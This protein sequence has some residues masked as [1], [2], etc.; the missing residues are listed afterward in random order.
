MAA[1]TARAVAA[2]APECVRPPRN[3]P[4]G[5]RVFTDRSSCVQLTAEIN[6][7]YRQQA[8]ALGEQP[9]H[10]SVED[11]VSGTLYTIVCVDPG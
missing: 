4:T 8:A 2:R 10:M 5:L 7:F 9:R 3:S 1:N 11:V 6:E